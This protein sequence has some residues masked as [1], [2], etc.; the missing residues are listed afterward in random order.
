MHK[1]AS[2]LKLFR[3]QESLGGMES[4]LKVPY[5]MQAGTVPLLSPEITGI[6]DNLIRLSVGCEDI[7]DIIQDLLQSFQTL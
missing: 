1:W 5:F 2:N 6:K 3:I 4:T 7:H